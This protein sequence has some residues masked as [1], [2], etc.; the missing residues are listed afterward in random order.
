MSADHVDIWYTCTEHEILMTGNK[1]PKNRSSSLI[2]GSTVPLLS[3]PSMLFILSFLT[4]TFSYYNVANDSM[5]HVFISSI[6]LRLNACVHIYFRVVGIMADDWNV[7]GIC[8]IPFMHNER[9]GHGSCYAQWIRWLWFIP[10]FSHLSQHPFNIILQ[11][12]MPDMTHDHSAWKACCWS[13]P[14]FDS[15]SRHP[16]IWS[17]LTHST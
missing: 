14:H 3:S 8:C 12:T 13:P 9:H 15:L 10:L 6:L 5:L 4:A 1:T 16:S 7:V 2:L 11:S 17:Y